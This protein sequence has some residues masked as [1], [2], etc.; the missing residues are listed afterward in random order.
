MHCEHASPTSED[1][2]K[3]LTTRIRFTIGRIVERHRTVEAWFDSANRPRQV[4]LT[5]YPDDDFV[6]DT[7]TSAVVAFDTTGI[8]TGVTIVLPPPRVDSTVS[9]I[10]VLRGGSTVTPLTAADGKAA[11]VFG[12]WLW[13]QRCPGPD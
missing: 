8:A 11:L 13:E 7:V 2:K 6:F 5:E 3:G 4:A 10:R 1:L 12:R 9:P